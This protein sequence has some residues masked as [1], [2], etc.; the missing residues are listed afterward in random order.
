MASLEL[1][2][3][4]PE[5]QL[6]QIS[7]G[8]SVQITSDVDKCINYRGTVRSQTVQTGTTVG[9]DPN[10][11]AVEITQ[12]VRAGDRVVVAGAGYLKDG[13]RVVVARS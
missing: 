8:E 6:P 4:V 13:D 5:T 7:P 11:S 10:N 1:Q 9:S 2:V 12:G 3:R